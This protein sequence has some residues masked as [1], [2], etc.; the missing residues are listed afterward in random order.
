MRFGRKGD[1]IYFRGNSQEVDITDLRPG[2]KISDVLCCEGALHLHLAQTKF[3]I[4]YLAD[5]QALVFLAKIRHEI[6]QIKQTTWANTATRS[7]PNV[8]LR[9]N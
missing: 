9:R 8:F 1:L 6:L 7:A 2:N 5:S 3:P 4:R